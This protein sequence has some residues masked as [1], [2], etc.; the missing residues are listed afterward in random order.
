MN[1]PN[2]ISL[3]HLPTPLEKLKFRNKKFLTL[4][5]LK[6][7]FNQKHKVLPIKDY[8][9]FPWNFNQLKWRRT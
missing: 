8:A 4:I 1:I 7:V 6:Y 3:A 2:K 5:K 9:S